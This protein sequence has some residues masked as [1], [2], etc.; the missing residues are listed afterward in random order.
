MYVYFISLKHW[1]WDYADGCFSEEIASGNAVY[2]Y[3]PAAKS[4]K[5]SM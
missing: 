5:V 4:V 3:E 2:I 1:F